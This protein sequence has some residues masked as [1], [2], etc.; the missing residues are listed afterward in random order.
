[1]ILFLE[2]YQILLTVMFRLDSFPL[3]HLFL[4]A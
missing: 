4:L 1:M 3:T 2:R